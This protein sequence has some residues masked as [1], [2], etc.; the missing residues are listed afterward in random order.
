MKK[1]TR[2]TFGAVACTLSTFLVQYA[3]AEEITG[4][5]GAGV[6]Y[7]PDYEGSD[8]YEFSP[9]GAARVEYSPY[10]IKT[11]ELGLHVNVSPFETIEFGLS[12]NFR[13]G[14]DDGVE[15]ATVLRLD[16]IDSA[17]EVGAFTRLKTS[18]VL[19]PTDELHFEVDILWDVTGVHEGMVVR[20]GPGYDYSPTERLRLGAKLMAVWASDEFNDT[21]FSINPD[22][23][24]R[25]GLSEYEASAGLKNVSFGVS[26]N[27]M[28][29]DNWGV[30]GIV[31]YERL[32][33]DAVDSPVV[34]DRGD[35]NQFF[36][37][38]GISYHF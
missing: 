16:E 1:S 30:I 27:Y 31:A 12:T 23:A 10:Y 38:S 32:L 8:D 25:S 17:F 6:M 13:D 18:G 20:F 29:T 21:Y 3:S 35:A 33:G 14:R 4:F 28:F 22:N 9:V 7:S 36:L 19:H 5:V 2:L 26:A 24:T 37:I 11:N 15:D 34:E